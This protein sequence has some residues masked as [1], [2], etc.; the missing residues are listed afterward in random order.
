VTKPPPRTAAQRKRDTLARLEGDIDAWVATAD[1]Q[2]TAYLVPLSFLWDG[3][4]L[5]VATP[6]ES[7]T[8]RNLRAGRRARL[9]V[10]PTRDVVLMD[11][12]VEAFSLETVPPGL[13]EEFAARL[14]DVR[15]EKQRYGYFRFT[16]V[17]IQ[18]WRESN[19][20]AGRD[21]MRDGRWLA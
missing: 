15:Q 19:E 10:G 14:W 1:P 2:G 6:Q 13:G 20:L 9:A 18:A 16:P 7:P 12:T 21:L 5:T 17:R 11:G 3:A 8:G 4:T